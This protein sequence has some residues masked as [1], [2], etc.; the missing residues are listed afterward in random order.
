MKNAF[1]LTLKGLIV[2]KVFKFLS[3]LFGH[4]KKKAWLKKIGLILKFITSQPGKQRIGMHWLSNISKSKVKQTIKF[5]QL[6]EIFFLKSYTQN[7]VKKLF[8]D[9]FLKS[10]N[11]AYSG[12]IV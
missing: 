2:H 5:G 9:P 7:V 6:I 11:W 12:S 3:W 10:Q 8:P 4:V 1:Y